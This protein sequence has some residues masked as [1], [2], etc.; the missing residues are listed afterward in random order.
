MPG[1]DDAH[2][3]LD[4]LPDECLAYIFDFLGSLDRG[5]C[6]LVCRRWL[7]VEGQNQHH[8]NLRAESDLLPVIPSLF[9]R[10]DAVTQLTLKGTDHRFV[11]DAL[12]L[13]SLHCHNLTSL[14]IDKC[15]DLID[16][17]MMAVAVNCKR[18]K[19]LSCHSCKFSSKGINAVLDHCSS[20]QVMSLSGQYNVDPAA[21]AAVPVRSSNLRS[22][23]ILADCTGDWDNLL[24]DIVERTSTGL[25]EVRLM[26]FR[27]SDVGLAA[28][29]N[30]SNLERLRLVGNSNCTDNAGIVSIANNCKLLSKLCIHGSNNNNKIDDESLIA[31]A[32]GCPNLEELALFGINLT[33]LSLRLLGAN[34]QNLNY[35]V[36]RGSDKIGDAEISCIATTCIALRFLFIIDCPAVTNRGMEV[37][38]AACPNR[39][40]I[41]LAFKGCTTFRFGG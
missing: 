21:S 22:L 33:C 13:L 40:R 15:H 4:L 20:L 26:Y 17:G 8:L 41:F 38:S 37:L 36:L 3:N 28:I 2:A 7:L 35:L 31:I 23:E 6:S 27:I 14:K 24:T 25:V 34:C 11:D 18:L 30:C 32:K 9:I 1:G 16:A 19:K 10:F 12:V 29:S 5:N 39:L